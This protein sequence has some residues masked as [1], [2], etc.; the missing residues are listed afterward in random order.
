MNHPQSRQRHQ[1]FRLDVH[2]NLDLVGIL[3]F[4]WPV[5]SQTLLQ[6]SRTFRFMRGLLYV[7]PHFFHRHLPCM[8]SDAIMPELLFQRHKSIF[9]VGYIQISPQSACSR[10][11]LTSNKSLINLSRS[12]FTFFFHP[13]FSKSNKIINQVHCMSLTHHQQ[14]CQ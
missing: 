7:E 10:R 3:I 11:S 5:L 9:W 6:V 4:S 14:C 1:D 13:L 12:F 8:Q 2:S